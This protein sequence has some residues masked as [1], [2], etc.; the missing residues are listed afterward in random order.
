MRIKNSPCKD[1]M[2]PCRRSSLYDVAFFFHC[3]ISV[4]ATLTSLCKTF[5]Q[6]CTVRHVFYLS[7]MYNSWRVVWHYRSFDQCLSRSIRANWHSRGVHLRFLKNKTS[8][9]R[10]LKI[11][12]VYSRNSC[13][14][15][16]LHGFGNCPRNLVWNLWLD[17]SVGHKFR[18]T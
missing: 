8:W 14:E 1:L 13:C 4:L 2:Q 11:F 15:S 9:T 12:T 7:L 18:T 17:F 6:L 10:H 3:T 5:S 16:R